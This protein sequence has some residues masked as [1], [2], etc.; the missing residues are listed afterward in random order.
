MLMCMSSIANAAKDYIPEKAYIYRDTIVKE[1][2]NNFPNIPEYNYI[3]SLIELESCISLKH[4]KCWTSTSELKSAREQGV[5]LGQITRAYKVDGS[6]RFDSLK[7][8]KNRYKEQL[9]EASWDSIKTRPDVQI[10]IIIL[11]VRDD[12]KR[13][14]SIPDEMVR[15]QMSDAAY[16]GG[17]GGLE[18]DRRQCGLKKGC[19]PKIWFDNVE[20]TCTKSKKILYANNNACDINRHHV[21]GVIKEKLPK[22]KKE[23]IVKKDPEPITEPEVIIEPVVDEKVVEEVLPTIE[24]PKVDLKETITVVN[25]V[26]VKRPTALEHDPRLI[27][28]WYFFISLVGIIFLIPLIFIVYLL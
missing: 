24:V 27:Y 25:T 21:K 19:D 2:D 3:P 28:L 7:E 10:R 12:Y 4:S 8:M 14:Y 15:L 17:Y 18:K 13:L 1:L 16:N 9:K 6:I 5:G 22:Y 26:E 11:M 20:L 23:Y